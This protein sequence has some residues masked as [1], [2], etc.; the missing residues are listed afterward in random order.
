VI[1]SPLLRLARALRDRS[2]LILA[3]HG[4]SHVSPRDDPEN[5]LVSPDRFR[6]Q[7]DLLV[8]AGF[9]FVTVAALAQ[10]AGGGPPPPGLAAL[11]FDD[12][13]ED[14][15]AVLLPIL[16]EYGVPATVYVA[17][18]LIG[19]P[20]PW[21]AA[22]TGARMMTEAELRRLAAAGIELGAHTVSHPDLSLLEREA[23]LREM[24]DSREALE[25][26]TGEPVTTFA[27][28]FC[29]YGEAAL[30][31]VADA[32]FIAAVTCEGRGSWN[33]YEMKRAMITGKDGPVSFM[34]KIS[35]AYQTLFESVPGRLLRTTT[36]GI[37]SRIRE[38]QTRSRSSRRADAP[39]SGDGEV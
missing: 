32:G 22:S 16:Q 33:R 30:A 38:R 10:T 27:Y 34:L 13:M 17:T 18:G 19:S 6:S 36:R 26:L 37:R 15:H 39:S 9:E 29:R 3:Y 11:S 20:N 35:G 5:L 1:A 31:A 21:M 8:D 12:G 4:V 14:N 7:L 28:P 2:S 23:C 25:R 24:V